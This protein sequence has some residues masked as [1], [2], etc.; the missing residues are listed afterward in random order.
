EGRHQLNLLVGKRTYFTASQGQNTDCHT[1]A[2]HW[3]GKDCSECAKLQRPRQRV[4][5][6]GLH[7]VHVN[8]LSFEQTSADNRAPSSLDRNTFPKF[9]GLQIFIVTGSQTV[10]L[11]FWLPNVRNFRLTQAS[12]RLHERVQHH[13]QVKRRTTDNL[14]H[15]SGRGLL[16][17]RLAQF[18]KETRVLNGD[19]GFR[20][21][22]LSQRD[23]LVRKRLHFL[24]V[25]VYGAD[26]IA[27]LEHRHR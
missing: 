11:A 5:T 22:D 12:G 13:L 16:L 6:I 27:L 21:E 24:S 9:L 17:K 14:Q 19:N 1:F 23:L 26:K 4:I 3:D 25:D 15:V 20:R 7:I 2:Q 8:G 10:G 18:T